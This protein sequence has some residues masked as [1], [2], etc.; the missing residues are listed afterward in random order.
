MQN[1]D[2]LTI[3]PLAVSFIVTAIA[4][5]VCLIFLKKYNIVDDPK[6]H[7]HPAIIH[8]KPIPRAEG[9]RFLSGS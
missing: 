9:F 6:K 2:F 7:K 3:L 8:E 4:T 1:F 5:P